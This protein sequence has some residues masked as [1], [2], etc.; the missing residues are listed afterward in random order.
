MSRQPLLMLDLCCGLKGAS[1]AMSERDWR[2][3]TLDNDPQF[4]PDVLA[5][6]SGWS[7]QG[8]RPDLVWASPPC[9]EFSRESFPWTR[10]GKRPDMTVYLACRRIIAEVHPRFWIIENVR[11]AVPYFGK[12]VYVRFPYYLWGTFPELGRFTLRRRY[13]DNFASG[14]KANRA[15]IPHDLSLAVAQAVEYSSML[16]E[17]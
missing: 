11:G 9:S 1:A 2:V 6:I 4:K 5:D 15:K 16:M 7:Y 10:T 8:D 13:K 14:D 12:Y 3:I 17:D